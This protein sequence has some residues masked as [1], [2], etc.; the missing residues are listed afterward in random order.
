[1]EWAVKADERSEFSGGV[2]GRIERNGLENGA[3][4]IVMH[5]HA[6]GER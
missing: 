4:K 1:M 5:A 3:P 6:S 2:R